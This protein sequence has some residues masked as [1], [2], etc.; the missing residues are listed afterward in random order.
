MALIIYLDES[1]DLGWDFAAPYRSGGS[2]RFLTIGALC[3]PPAKR[4]IPKRL[5]KN[6]CDKFKWN[7][8]NEK[9]WSDMSDAAR[10]EFA[11]AARRLCDANADIHLRCIT[12]RKEKVMQHIRSDA[13]KLYNYMIR[14]SLLDSMA[15]HDTVTMVPDPRT[16]KVQSG[17]SLHD[18]LQIELWF[19][20]K[21]QTK[22]VSAPQDSQHCRGIQFTDMLC[23]LVQSHFEDGEQPNFRV[24]SPKI[25]I[26]RLYFGS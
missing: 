12:V 8:T 19:A 16:I 25:D 24:L 5:I 6:L 7:P 15:T 10:R 26:S 23:G 2:S 3:V 13:N 20:R 22:L 1:G 18:Y 21:A 9:K 4:H 14:L 17:N 11:E